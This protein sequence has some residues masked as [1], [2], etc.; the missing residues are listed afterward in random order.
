MLA[1]YDNIYLVIVP[2]FYLAHSKDWSHGVSEHLS[3]RASFLALQPT[4]QC[5]MHDEW[6]RRQSYN[7][8]RK[9]ISNVF[10]PCYILAN[11]SSEFY[12]FSSVELCFS[13]SLGRNQ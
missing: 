8:R 11:L 4:Y 5:A 3:H 13:E 6:K 2:K 9:Q 7:D 1:D 10:Q 12:D